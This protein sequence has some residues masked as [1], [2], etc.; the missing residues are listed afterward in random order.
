MGAVKDLMMRYCETIHPDDWD[1]QDELF[2][3]LMSSP[4][5][6]SLEDMVRVVDEF[7][8]SGRVP[9]QPAL[10]LHRVCNALGIKKEDNH[11]R[12]DD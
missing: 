6:P 8:K 12:P 9:K 2:T 11:A 4:D 1:K 3:E 10:T 5:A 7:E